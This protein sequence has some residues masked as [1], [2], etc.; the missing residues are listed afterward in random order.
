MKD[1]SKCKGIPFVNRIIASD[2]KE[3]KE[4]EKIREENDR[5]FV[6]SM[7]QVISTN[8]FIAPMM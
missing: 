6:Q 1:K 8:G 2:E 5:K 3:S 4:L 7:R